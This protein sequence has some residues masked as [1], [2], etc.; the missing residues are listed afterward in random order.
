MYQTFNDSAKAVDYV[1]TGLA[2]DFPD[3]TAEVIQ[4]VNNRPRRV[5]CKISEVEALL[6]Q[7]CKGFPKAS[8][9]YHPE[10]AY[11]FVAEIRCHGER[12]R[13][14]TFE[15]HKRDRPRVPVLLTR[16]AGKEVLV[17]SHMPPK[18]KETADS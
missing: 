9:E 3:A 7:A 17:G 1:A 8:V 14:T 5:S 18:G 10:N 4:V 15:R 6:Q 12:S 11:G 2:R 13:S 16:V